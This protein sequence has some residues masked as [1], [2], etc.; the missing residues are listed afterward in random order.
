MGRAEDIFKM[1]I[2]G[3]HEAIDSFIENAASEELFLDFKRSADAGSGV[4]L[5][6]TDRAN[7]AKAISGFGN[8]EGGVVVWG[9]DCSPAPSTGDVATER[10]PIQQPERFKSWLEGAVSG[11]TI[12]PHGS[13]QHHVLAKDEKD[14]DL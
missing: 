14:W 9:I 13:V 12:P 2:E 6:P 1:L 10:V 7:L 4:R 3:G 11:L 5:H 8:S